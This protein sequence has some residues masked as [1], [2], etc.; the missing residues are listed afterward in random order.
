[1]LGHDGKSPSNPTYAIRLFRDRLEL[2]SMSAA[3]SGFQ[4]DRFP[5]R[6]HAYRSFSDANPMS[7]RITEM[8]QNRTTTVA[9]CQPFCSK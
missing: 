7:A 4:T 5:L 6:G 3:T 8:I 2:P 1:M 9:S